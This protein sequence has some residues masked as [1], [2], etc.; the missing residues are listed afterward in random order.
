MQSENIHWTKWTP[1]LFDDTALVAD[2]VASIPSAPNIPWIVRLFENPNSPFYLPG[3]TTMLMHD[4][5]H[6]ILGR[7][8]LN[9]DEA[10]VIGFGM[11]SSL[12]ATQVQRMVF[13]FVSTTF[14]PKAYRFNNN[15]RKIFNW[16]FEM[17]QKMKIDSLHL[18]DERELGR[19]TIEEVRKFY[20]IDNT[21]LKKWYAEEKR[22]CQNTTV[23]NRLPN[24]IDDISQQ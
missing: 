11:G 24:L 5:I 20:N 17:A 19:M 13:E 14:Y 1:W 15:E 22:L 23:S 12:G 9:Q 2:V 7:G 3:P 8:L 18:A 6:V 10:F 4:T 21:L 16:G